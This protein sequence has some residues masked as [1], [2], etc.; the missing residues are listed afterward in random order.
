MM[1]NWETCEQLRRKRSLQVEPN[2]QFGQG[3]A[4]LPVCPQLNVIKQSNLDK[5][6]VDEGYCPEAP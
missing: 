5:D 1:G 3:R 4:E 2:L 6:T